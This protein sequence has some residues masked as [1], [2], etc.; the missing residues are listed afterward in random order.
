M[1][2]DNPI[3]RTNDPVEYLSYD[4]EEPEPGVALC[5]S[6]G[7]YRAMVFHVGVIWRLYESG[8][9]AKLDRV[10]SVSGGSIAAAVLGLAWGRLNV[11]APADQSVFMEHFVKP[12]L[13]LA[14]ETIDAWGIVG[15][16][17]LPGTISEKIQ[18][19]YR[20]HLFGD[21]TLQDLVDKPR[22]VINAINVQSGVLWR[23]SKP[24][25]RD[26]R[27]GEVKAPRISLA[28]AVAASSAFPPVLSPMIMELDPTTFTPNSGDD[29]QREPYTSR[30]V[31]SDGGVYDNLGL[32]TAWKRYD[33]ILVSDAGGQLKPEDEPK[34]DWARHSY[35][36]LNLIDNQVRSLRKRQ[37]IQSYCD[38]ARKGA[39]WGI[40][41][42]I[43]DYQLVDTLP[44]PHDRTL[45]LAATPTRLK[46]MDNNLQERLINWGY[47]VCDAALRKHVDTS[48]SQG[49]FPYPDTG[50]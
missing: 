16:I 33:T 29:L 41:T 2:T 23:F 10:S 22:F 38:K 31:L 47:A 1:P 5:L 43:A 4:R 28:K 45:A 25:M 27:V 49:K 20:K 24:Y 34:E 14:G 11:D 17:L 3:R 6:G 15:G 48:L 46:R 26:Y 36:V 13:T 40:R 44:C 21:A 37:V 42:N 8:W 50:I 19:S 12:I 7:G 9:L 18:G 30:V 39:Y 35:R 32:E